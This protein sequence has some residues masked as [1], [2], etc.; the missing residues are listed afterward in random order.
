[1]L[2]DSIPIENYIFSLSHAEIGIGNKIIESF[3]RWISKYI[4]LLSNEEIEMTNNLIDL[5]IEQIQNKKLF[6]Q[7]KHQNVTKIADLTTEKKFIKTALKN[8]GGTSR[9]LIYGD[10]KLEFI[11]ELNKIKTE[12]KK[13]KDIRKEKVNLSSNKQ[14]IEYEEDSIKGYRNKNGKNMTV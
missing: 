12:I 7:I 1:M 13:L 11:E 3:Y 5:Q 14:C 10:L 9:Y 6:K 2:F 8:K 4:E